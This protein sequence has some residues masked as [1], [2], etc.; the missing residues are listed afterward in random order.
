MQKVVKWS[1]LRFK[2]NIEYVIKKRSYRMFCKNTLQ[3]FRVFKCTTGILLLWNYRK[4]YLFRIKILQKKIFE[5]D[6][7]WNISH[8][9]FFYMNRKKNFILIS[10]LRQKIINNN[11]KSS[12]KINYNVTIHNIWSINHTYLHDL[13]ETKSLNVFRSKWWIM[14]AV[15]I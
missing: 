8:R 11:N 5:I 12:I 9:S 14:I 2:C 6:L 7:V 4:N 1:K 10:L 13:K 3:I 15:C